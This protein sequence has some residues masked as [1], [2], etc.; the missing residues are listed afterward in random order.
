MRYHDAQPEGPHNIEH[1][2]LPDMDR[3]PEASCSPTST[4]STNLQIIRT[5]AN[6]F[7]VYREF[8]R[9]P[10]R[11]PDE[12]MHSNVFSIYDSLR[13]SYNLSTALLPFP[14]YTTYLIFKH[15]YHTTNKTNIDAE[16]LA[17]IVRVRTLTLTPDLRISGPP[18]L[19]CA[20]TGLCCTA[21]FGLARHSRA[22]IHSPTAPPAT[23]F[24][25]HFAYL[26]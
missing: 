5:C 3:P 20:A 13:T 24:L 2:P 11:V 1:P 25:F 6:A 8:P 22:P 9:L 21:T 16:D 23:A 15:H 26:S 12:S 7:G 17:K 18:D 19:R 10:E 14:N 4:P